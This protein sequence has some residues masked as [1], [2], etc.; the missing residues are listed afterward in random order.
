MRS[1]PGSGWGRS[2]RGRRNPRRALGTAVGEG[3][4]SAW[5][6]EPLFDEGILLLVGV[7]LRV[8][9]GTR[10]PDCGPCGLAGRSPR[11]RRNLFAGRL[12]VAFIGSISA[13]AEEPLQRQSLNRPAWVD[14]RVGGGT[15]KCYWQGDV[16]WGRSPRGRRNLE[17]AITRHGIGGSIS[18]WAEEP[19]SAEIKIAAARVDLRVGGGTM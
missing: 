15:C 13:W 18:A 9:G 1:R 10:A 7:D 17:L 4:I 2:P 14:L 3:S 19:A 12:V 5:A 8:G 6:E 16:I 11:G